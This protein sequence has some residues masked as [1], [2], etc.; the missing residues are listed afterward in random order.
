MNPKDLKRIEEEE[1]ELA[2]NRALERKAGH[3]PDQKRMIF[4]NLIEA[5]VY[6]NPRE[7]RL[8]KWQEPTKDS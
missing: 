7:E 1:R 3:V 5:G 6:I 4:R 8:K 2:E